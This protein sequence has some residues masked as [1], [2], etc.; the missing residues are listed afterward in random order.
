VEN[1]HL[2]R[3]V[4]SG[5]LPKILERLMNAYEQLQV[6]PRK[7]LENQVHILSAESARLKVKLDK[8]ETLRVQYKRL[9]DEMVEERDTTHMRIP[10][11]LRIIGDYQASGGKLSADEAAAKRV[12]KKR[13]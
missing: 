1:P 5:K 7:A 4:T 13:Y 8:A 11:L 2:R 9:Y 6:K 12:F 3:L 10:F